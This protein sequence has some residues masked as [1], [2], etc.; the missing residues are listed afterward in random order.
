MPTRPKTNCKFPRCAQLIKPGDMYC[1]EHKKQVDAD[2]NR[3]RE[4]AH[5]KMY[6]K[7]WKKAREI[8]LSQNPLCEECKRGGRIKAASEIDHIKPHDGNMALFWDSDNNWQA[9][10]K[11]CHSRKTARE[12]SFTGS[13][14]R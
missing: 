13:K 7:R 11:P 1:A 2:Y 10:C 6:A 8:Y 5:G 9:L 4:T 12:S 3:N 14:V